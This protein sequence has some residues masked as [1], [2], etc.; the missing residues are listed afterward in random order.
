MGAK[1]VLGDGR[2]ARFWLDVW[3]G[4]SPLKDR[5]PL[6]FAICDDTEVTVAQVLSGTDINLRLRRS[7]DQVGSAQ[8]AP[9]LS[10]GGLGT[11]VP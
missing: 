5:F 3:S 8:W 4:A 11:T 9:A 7:L 10:G 1:F 6:I 2:R